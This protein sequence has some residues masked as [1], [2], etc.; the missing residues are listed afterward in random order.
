MYFGDVLISAAYKF[1][2]TPILNVKCVS[3]C[4]CVSVGGGGEGGVD[5]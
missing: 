4:V 2:L 5:H 1:P 3:E